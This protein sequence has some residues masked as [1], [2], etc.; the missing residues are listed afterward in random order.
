MRVGTVAGEAGLPGS[1]GGAPDAGRGA[2]HV[3]RCARARSRDDAT[4]S[5]TPAGSG[6]GLARCSSKRRIGFV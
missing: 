2:A 3:G 1:L 5:A 4:G 6:I